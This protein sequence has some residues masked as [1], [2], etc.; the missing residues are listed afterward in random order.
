M[1]LLLPFLFLFGGWSTNDPSG[2]NNL[3]ST[4]LGEYTMNTLVVMTGVGFLSLLLGG[5]FA[6]LTSLYDFPLRRF[7]SIA[8]LLPLALT[9]TSYVNKALWTRHS[10]KAALLPPHERK[11]LSN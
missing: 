10:T 3:R 9:I 11:S 7:F 2:W 5:G 4:V 8:L 6:I 1:L